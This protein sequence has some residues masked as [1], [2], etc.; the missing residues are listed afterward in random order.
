[1][2]IKINEE[3]NE[4]QQQIVGF[5]D[6]NQQWI[7]S[8]DNPLD[9][10]HSTADS[11][12]ASLENFFSRP[13]KIA[14]LNW[15]VGATFG[16]TINPWQ[17]YFENTRV[18]NRITNYN[19]LRS[20]LC[21]RIMI[22]GNG[23]HYGRALAS[24]RPLHNQDQFTPWRYGLVNEDTIGASQRMHVWIDPTKSQG[25]TLCLPYVYYKNTMNVV[26]EEWRDMGVLDIASVTTLEHANGVRIPLPF[27]YLRGLKM[28]LFQFQQLRN[29]VLYH[30]KS[31]WMNRVNMMR[32]VLVQFLDLQQ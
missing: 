18:I 16:T 13:I 28:F 3:S 24:Y 21:V 8:I 4:T 22:N 17:L 31:C 9:D 20:K 12:D 5:S 26:E 2:N 27:L 23:F 25:G 32:L 6:Q 14:S 15:P 30:P 7:Y 10:V 1:M 29:L 11:N 19:L